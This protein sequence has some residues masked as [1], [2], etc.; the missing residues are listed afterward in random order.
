MKFFLADEADRN[1]AQ[2]RG[3]G[4]VLSL[5]FSSGEDRYQ[6]EPAHDETPERIFERRWALSVL[7]RV[8]EKLRN[9]F[10][11]HGR[12]EHFERLKVFLLG[13][14]DAP[15]ATLAREMNTSE[16][17]LKSAIPSLPHTYRQLFLHQTPATTPYPLAA[18]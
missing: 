11:H 18:D 8:V 7:D 6:R 17:A 15:Y 9:E 4:T 16:G 13:Q 10:V 2:K 12:P 14:S 1:R 3:G 5:E